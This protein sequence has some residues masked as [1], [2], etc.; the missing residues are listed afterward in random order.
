VS[1][2]AGAQNSWTAVEQVLGRTGA[3]M[4]GGVSRYSFPRRDLRVTVDGIQLKPAF[5]LGTWVAFKRVDGGDAM[6]MGD[7]VLIESEINPVISALQAG[8]VEQGALHNHLLGETPHVMYL[9]IRGHGKEADLARTVRSAL[10]LTKTPMDTVQALVAAT[11][12]SLD[13]AALARA[14]GYEG[15]VNGGVYQVTVPRM[16]TIMEGGVEIPPSMGMATPMNFQPTDGGRAMI[17]GDF[18]MT[19]G[20]VNRVIRALRANGIAVA[21][22]HSHML[23]ESPRLLFMHF[24][25]HDDAIKLARGLAAGL[26]ETN[27]QKPTRRP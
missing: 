13:T 25:A 6:I 27:S 9:H 17:S 2:T 20:E 8:G 14:L 11:A 4:A 24:W 1:T 19:A 15:K 22:I 16:E 3:A 18:V 5:A 7:L 23:D 10:A 12:F 21:S 26:A